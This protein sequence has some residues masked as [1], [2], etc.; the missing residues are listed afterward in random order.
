VHGDREHRL[1]NTL[2]AAFAGVDANELLTRLGD[3]VAAS[4]GAACHSHRVSVS[5]V[6]AAMD[7]DTATALS[8]VR[9]SVGRFTT[10]DEIDRATA[11]I[12]QEIDRQRA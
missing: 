12:L 11:T 5:H 2:S 8:T 1:P 9:L 3:R 10:E 7:V 4:A 6:L